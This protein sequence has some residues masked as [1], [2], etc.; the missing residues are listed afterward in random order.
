MK[1]VRKIR[2]HDQVVWHLLQA[3]ETEGSLLTFSGG[4]NPFLGLVVKA[5]SLRAADLGL[6]PA[7]PL[8]LLSR[9]GHTSDLAMGTNLP[10]AWR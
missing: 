7:F 1:N 3:W 4:V 8:D 9:S 5:S 2:W 6:I 10:G